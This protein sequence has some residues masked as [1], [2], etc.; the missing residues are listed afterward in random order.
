MKT[1]ACHSTVGCNG[2][3]YG[4]STRCHRQTKNYALQ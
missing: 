4:V 1:T 3:Q 2:F